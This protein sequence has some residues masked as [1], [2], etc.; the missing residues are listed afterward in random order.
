MNGCCGEVKR[1][2]VEFDG[3]FLPEVFFVLFAVISQKN[4]MRK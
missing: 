2:L 3:D 1:L 4:Y